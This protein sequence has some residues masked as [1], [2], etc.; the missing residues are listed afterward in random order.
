MCFNRGPVIR[1]MLWCWILKSARSMMDFVICEF[2]F[3]IAWTMTD[4]FRS[5][6]STDSNTST[7]QWVIILHFLPVELMIRR[8]YNDLIE[9]N[10]PGRFWGKLAADLSTELRRCYR[11]S[12]NNRS[13][14]STSSAKGHCWPSRPPWL[15]RLGGNPEHLVLRI[16]RKFN[17]TSTSEPSIHN[18]Q[19]FGINTTHLDA[20]ACWQGLPTHWSKPGDILLIRTGW[21][22]QYLNLTTYN[23]EILPWD[24]ELGSVGMNASDDSLA[25]LWEKK[26]ALVGADNPAFES[27]PFDKTV[28][29]VPR[30]MHQVFIGGELKILHLKTGS[31][32][33]QH[34]LGTKYHGIP[35]PWNIGCGTACFETINILPDDP[36]SEYQF[37]NCF[38]P[39]CIGDTV[40]GD[41]RDGEIQG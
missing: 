27:T 39:K 28:S 16:H 19:G 34:R 22:K 13:W 11:A 38:A 35:W 21:I 26:L 37:R 1:M 5:P 3:W 40:R 25:W 14:H 24:P 7:Y 31:A 29:G 15:C 6:Y 9:V 32:K 41:F 30:S 33:T 4:G 18:L 17:P 8:W 20:V 36:E 23:Q 2:W 10:L 12:A